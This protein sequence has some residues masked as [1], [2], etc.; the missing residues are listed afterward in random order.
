MLSHS[1]AISSTSSEVIEMY[2]KY[3]NNLT[4]M[5]LYRQA[6]NIAISPGDGKMVV[7]T[8]KFLMPLLKAS[9]CKNYA[10]AVF[11]LSAQLVLLS[12]CHGL[13]VM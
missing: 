9:G 12:P 1:T 10:L 11:E 3:Y 2:Q 4:I 13:M 6:L 8:V 7:I 5:L